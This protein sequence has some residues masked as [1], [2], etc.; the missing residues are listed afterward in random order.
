MAE[1]NAKSKANNS[2]LKD[3]FRIMKMINNM[4]SSYIP[5]ITIQTLM[6]AALPFVNIIYG[7]KILD[8]ITAKES[9]GTLISYVII[10]V[11]SNLVMGLLKTAMDKKRLIDERYVDGMNGAK[12]SEKSL[13]L[14]Y[15]ILEKKET[16][17]IL[18]KAEDG[19]NTQGGL[20]Y[21][22]GTVVGLIQHFFLDYLCSGTGS[23][24]I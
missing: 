18:K 15:E 4:R 10:M 13:S 24:L 14:D 23:R 8:G 5:L 22:C 3:I 6:T 11:V 9:K 17:E 7:S 1:W 21:L 12:I 20:A 16:L 19:S 2:V